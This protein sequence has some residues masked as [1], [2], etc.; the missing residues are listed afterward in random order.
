MKISKTL[1]KNLTRCKN[2]ASLYDMYTFRNMHHIKSIDGVDINKS[3]GVLEKLS[4]GIF[5]EE[6]DKAMEIFRHM[7]DDETGEDLTILSNAQMEAYADYFKEIEIIA[8]KMIEKKFPGKNIYSEDTKTQKLFSF[9]NEKHNYYCYLDIYNESDDGKIRIF[10]VKATTTNKFYKLGKDLKIESEFVRIPKSQAYDSIFVKCNDGIMRLKEELSED[11]S[12]PDLPYISYMQ[13]REKLFKRYSSDGCG[14]YV[15][16]IAVERYIIENS[17]IQSNLAELIPNI[18]YYLVVLNGDYVY[19]GKIED[20]KCV[21]ETD[22]NGNEVMAFID[23]TTITKEWQATIDDQRKFIENMIEER[24]IGHICTSE[25]CELKKSTQCKFK[26]VCYRDVTCDG[27]ILEYLKKQYAF[28]GPSADRGLTIYDLI[29]NGYNK[30]DSIP[31]DYLDKPANLIQYDCYTDNKTFIDK[32]K[33]QLALDSLQYPLYHLDFETFAS[34]LPRYHDEVPYMQSV[35]QFSLHIEKEKYMCDKEKDHYEYLAPDHEDHRRDLCEAM[36]KYI[37]LSK[38]GMV[39]VYNENFERT[40]LKELAMIYPDLAEPLLKIRDAIFDLMFVLTGSKKLFLPLLGDNFSNKKE[41]EKAASMINYYHNNLHGSYSIKKVLPIFS[42][43]NYQQLNDVHNGTE[44]VLVY[45][46]FPTYT[47][48][49]YE[50]KYLAL[51]KYCQQDTWAMVE[52]LWG[53]WKIK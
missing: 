8:G 29:N 11:P 27:S 39:I 3:L 35:F 17:L 1:F 52:I 40:R 31:R 24:T 4:E 47:E 49:E 25:C 38:G 14:K 21:Y 53:L 30:I 43:L 44:A 32:D 16:D 10:E 33:I 19:D 26:L 18:E 13:H 48:E 12:T 6:D 5:E 46:S 51:R 15:Y 42:N 41:K 45:G 37:D 2:F 50:S 7:F 34:P 20:G 23:L 9:C 22:K 36:I 28:T